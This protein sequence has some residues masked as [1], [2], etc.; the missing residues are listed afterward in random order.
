VTVRQKT[1]QPVR[2]ELTEQ[3][4]EAVDAYIKVVGSKPGQFLFLGRRGSQKALTTRQY[5]RLVTKWVASIGLDPSFF[6]TLP[7]SNEGHT[8]LWADW[9]PA[10]RSAAVGSHQN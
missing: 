5:V 1:G 6:G 2:F 3:T 7:T 4:R 9:K 10:R 8:H